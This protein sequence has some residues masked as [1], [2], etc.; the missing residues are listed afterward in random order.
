MNTLLTE[1]RSSL[2]DLDAGL[3]GALNITDAMETLA[4]KLNLN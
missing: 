2:N 3:R 4:V 1:I